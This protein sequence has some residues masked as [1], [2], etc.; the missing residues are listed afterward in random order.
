MTLGEKAGGLGAAG[1][2][3]D[4]A[5]AAGTATTALHRGQRIFL[6][7]NVSDSF[8]LTLQPGQGTRISGM[9]TSQEGQ[10]GAGSERGR[11][12]VSS[13]NASS[14]RDAAPS[15]PGVANRADD[16]GLPGAQ[17]ARASGPAAA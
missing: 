10:A 4:G 5:A 2:G 1:G 6:P 11:V 9:A 16:A 8:R 3:A 13:R 14:D 7:A 17:M 12:N 15:R